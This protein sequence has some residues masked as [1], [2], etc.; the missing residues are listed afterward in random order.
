MMIS[1]SAGLMS[2]IPVLAG[3]GPL[4]HFELWTVP[5]RLDGPEGNLTAL[6]DQEPQRAGGVTRRAA[7]ERRTAEPLTRPV[8]GGYSRFFFCSGLI[9]PLISSPYYLYVLLVL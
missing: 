1:L 3:K 5:D 8:C 7:A 9:F 4:R 6:L 2:N